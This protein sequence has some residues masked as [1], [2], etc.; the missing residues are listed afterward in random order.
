MVEAPSLMP[1]KLNPP[2]NTVLVTDFEGLAKVKDFLSSASAFGI[3]TETNITP[4]FVNRRIRTIQVGDKN[5]QYVIDL[6]AF[7][8]STANLVYFQGHNGVRVQQNPGL[9]AV[10]DVLR[11]HLESMLWLKVGAN[12]QFDYEVVKWCLGIRMW[13]LHDVQIVEKVIYA[14]LVDFFE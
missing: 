13:H 2:L 11:P 9:Q 7:A 6:L 14:G 3:D 1:E 5:E 12:L 4:T 8:G 10:V